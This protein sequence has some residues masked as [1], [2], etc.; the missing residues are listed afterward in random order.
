MHNYVQTI[1]ISEFATNNS[2]TKCAD[3]FFKRWALIGT[4]IYLATLPFVGI[5]NFLILAWF[6]ACLCAQ[7]LISCCSHKPSGLVHSWSWFSGVRTRIHNN[8]WLL[9]PRVRVHLKEMC[10]ISAFEAFFVALCMTFLT[11]FCHRLTCTRSRLF[12]E[13]QAVFHKWSSFTIKPKH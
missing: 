8:S 10:S 2:E 6:L 13:F 4:R 3:F 5:L 7:H 12:Y 1:Q 9:F 11:E